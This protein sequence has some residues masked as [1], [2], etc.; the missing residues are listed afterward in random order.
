MSHS[1]SIRRMAITERGSGMRST[2]QAWGVLGP[3]TARLTR[4]GTI[5]GMLLVRVYMID[6][7]RLSCRGGGWRTDGWAAHNTYKDQP[8]LLHTVH[9]SGEVV[10]QDDLSMGR[11]DK[12]SR[13][14]LQTMS[15]ASLETSEPAIPMATLH[16]TM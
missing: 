3:C 6:F 11:T 2:T 13:V 10:I 16:G 14:E 5:S 4:K 7:F 8:S 15:A 9:N 12:V 1:R